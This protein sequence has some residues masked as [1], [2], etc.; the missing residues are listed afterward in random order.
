[1]LVDGVVDQIL[2]G[3]LALVGES[4]L[5]THE[6]IIFD[7]MTRRR[8]KTNISD[9]GYL[10]SGVERLSSPDGSPQ[11]VQWSLV[12]GLQTFL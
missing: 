6:L 10:P 9:Y 8:L 5:Q 2:E 7:L 11:E 3:R 12:S 1:M 4:F